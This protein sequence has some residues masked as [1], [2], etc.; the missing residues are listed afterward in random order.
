MKKP[1]KK[2]P[3][4][5]GVWGPIAL[6]IVCALVWTTC[7]DC[8]SAVEKF[9]DEVTECVIAS[10]ELGAAEFHRTRTDCRA[11]FARAGIDTSGFK[12]P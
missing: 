9:D 1:A 8:K 11:P 2:K 7:I 4:E 12:E 3:R 10:Q 5:R 6:F